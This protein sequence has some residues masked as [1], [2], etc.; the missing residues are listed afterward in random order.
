MRNHDA[1]PFSRLSHTLP[2]R[3]RAKSTRKGPR[4]RSRTVDRPLGLAMI[5]DFSTCAYERCYGTPMP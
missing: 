1:A 5:D 3:G 4:S 2:R